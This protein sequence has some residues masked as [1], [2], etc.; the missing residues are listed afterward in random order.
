MDE[1]DDYFNQPLKK[2][3]SGWVYV[4]DYGD[5]K[6]FKIGYTTGEPEERVN[7]IARGTVLM[8]MRLVMACYTMTNCFYFENLLQMLL[9]DKH[10]RGEWFSLDFP[11]LVGLY[12]T[13]SCF[14]G[15]QL[16][17]RWFELVP[18]DY[19]EYIDHFSINDN[20]PHFDKREWEEDNNFDF[21]KAIEIL[22]ARNGQ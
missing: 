19:R 2:W 22:G 4:L 11:D 17:D 10:V 14:G 5:G 21:S 18:D 7:Q 20:Y 13:L 9:D 15:A 12:Q 8:P 3:L 16:Y 1:E 6:T